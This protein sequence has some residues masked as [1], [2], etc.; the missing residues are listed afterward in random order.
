MCIAQRSEAAMQG[1]GEGGSGPGSS[2]GRSDANLTPEELQARRTA[3]NQDKNRRAQR[4]FRQRQKV[5]KLLHLAPSLSRLCCTKPSGA[6]QEKLSD[7]EAQLHQCRKMLGREQEARRKT[8][9]DNQFLMQVGCSTML[10]CL[11]SASLGSLCAVWAAHCAH[12]GAGPRRAARPARGHRAQL[13]ALTST[14]FIS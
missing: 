13:A 9:T 3:L 7:A 2:P 10:C 8:E 5:P 6:L 1:D 4:R 12:C 11:L 14:L